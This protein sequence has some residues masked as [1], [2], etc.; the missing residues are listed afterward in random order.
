MKK[1]T[2]K[3]LWVGSELSL[4]EQLSLASF[5]KSGHDVQ[6]FTYG[7]V[8][9]VP[10][11][12]S[13]RDGNEILGEENVFM[14]NKKP[15]Y[16]GFAN[17]FRYEM[18]YREGGVWVDTDVVCLKKFDFDSQMFFGLEQSDAVNCAVVGAEPGIPMFQFLSEQ[19]R[20][21]NR[22]LPYDGFKEKKR[23]IFRK[24]IKGNKR[25]DLKWGESGPRGFTNALRHFNYFE[26]ALPITAFY[27][28]HSSCWT[29]IFDATYPD[30]SRYF[31]DTYAI[32]LWNEMIRRMDGFDKNSTF[33]E[34]SLIEALKRQYL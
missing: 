31:P 18:L 11:G 29:S 24:Y 34:D 28:V 2:I 7:D 3:A 5:V 17:W 13:L 33:R 22:F 15:S 26:Q 1:W 4:I 23:K 32:H 27:P 20:H 14:Y 10:E 8:A 9:N 21:P 12:V 16:S 30:P 25:G 6:L 19:V